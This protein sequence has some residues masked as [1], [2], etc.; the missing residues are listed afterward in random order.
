MR[1]SLSVTEAF[2]ELDR[3]DIDVIQGIIKENLE[4]A[5]KSNQPFF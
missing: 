2:N 1:G 3:E 4:T 5:K